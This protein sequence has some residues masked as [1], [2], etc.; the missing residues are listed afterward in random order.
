MTKSV[1]W[2][3]HKSKKK[4]DF[5]SNFCKLMNNAVFGK[6]MKNLKNIEVLNLSQK[7]EKVII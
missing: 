4:N 5:E 6:A 3:E 1:Y 2:F 7:K